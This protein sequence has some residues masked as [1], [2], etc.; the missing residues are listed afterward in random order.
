MGQ[1]TAIIRPA[2][3]DDAESIAIV[4]LEAARAQYQGLVADRALT[5]LSLGSLSSRWRALLTSRRRVSIALVAVDAD[6]RVLGF[7]AAGAN[8]SRAFPQ[9]GEIYAIYVRPSEQ[10]QGLGRRLFD[11][12]LQSLGE[13][14]MASVIAWVFAE[15][16]ARVFFEGLGGQWVATAYSRS[17]CS[18]VAYVWHDT[19]VVRRLGSKKTRADAGS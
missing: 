19:V 15:N 3:T 18:K 1:S 2:S 13:Q 9:A 5:D 11:H 4:Y 6:G 8:R 12:A 10:H 7:T 16:P 17:T 14:G